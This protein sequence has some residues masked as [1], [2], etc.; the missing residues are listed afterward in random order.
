M[1]RGGSPIKTPD[2][3][4]S[5]ITPSGSDGTPFASSRYRIFTGR[6]GTTRQFGEW[7]TWSGLVA[8]RSRL[9]AGPQQIFQEAGPGCSWTGFFV[10]LSVG[11][12][13]F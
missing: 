13:R 7:P 5:T 6:R 10:L 4:I 12:A 2:V 3:P 1:I 8:D 11:A 9:S